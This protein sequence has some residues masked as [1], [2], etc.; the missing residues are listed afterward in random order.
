MN[1]FKQDNKLKL[2]LAFSIVIGIIAIIIG[3]ANT[4]SNR[5]WVSLLF[6][7]LFFTGIALF[8]VFFVALQYVSQAGWSIVLKRIAESLSSYL[9]LGGLIMLAIILAGVL[10]LHHIYHSRLF[11]SF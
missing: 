5:I 3:F 7:N 8:G 4:D 6:N 10:D 1:T 11:L 9:P 2:L